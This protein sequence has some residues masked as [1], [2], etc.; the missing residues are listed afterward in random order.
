MTPDSGTFAV[1]RMR[2]S[3]Q[4][5][6]GTVLAGKRRCKIKEDDDKV[7]AISNMVEPP[8]PTF[9]LTMKNQL[10]GFSIGLLSS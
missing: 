9:G 4:D 5:Q 8:S 10:L 3:G 6:L 1:R 2:A 7:Y